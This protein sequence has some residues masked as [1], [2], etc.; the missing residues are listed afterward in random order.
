MRIIG[1]DLHARQ[2]VLAMLDATT[3]EVLSMMLK[4]EGNNVLEFY[5]RLAGPVRVG[6]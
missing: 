6:I 4:H 2:Q 1:C 5:A 3:G